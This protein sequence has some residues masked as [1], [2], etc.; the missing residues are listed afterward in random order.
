MRKTI[1][2]ALFLLSGCSF[3][4]LVVPN[5][6]YLIADRIDSNLHLYNDQEYQVRK[7]VQ[8]ILVD[9]KSRIKT[10]KSYLNQIDIKNIEE[11]KAYDFLVKNYYELALKVNPILARQF[12]SL[13]KKQILK[14]KKS[15]KKDNQKIEKRLKERK[16][17]DIS[18]RFSFFFGELTKDQKRF[19]ENNMSIYKK[20]SQERMRKRK[21]TQK[22]LS[23]VL[24]L[25][26]KRE[27]ERLI[28]AL[29][30]ENADRRTLTPLRRKSIVLFKEFVQT[31][32]PTQVN[33]FKK[34][35]LFFNEWI[36]EYLKNY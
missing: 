16:I 11:F 26:S 6:A 9:E 33:Y 22:S 23:S 10:I 36:D 25:N 34:K 13:D 15:L 35:T 14:F 27:K 2:L 31:L 1:F 32:T 19:V 18:K 12:S 4:S 5:L 30:N 3:K 17:Q 8:K 20:L 21:A 24:E 7:D 29:F 28:N